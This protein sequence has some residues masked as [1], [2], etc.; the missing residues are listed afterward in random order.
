MGR[1]FTWK[2]AMK[3]TFS[4]EREKD[5]MKVN[6][7]VTITRT[8]FITIAAENAEEAMKIVNEL[9]MEEIQCGANWVDD[10]VATD[11]ELEMDT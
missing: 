5:N 2:I 7:D 8:G 4:A 6:F 11:A 3:C 10:V 1:R 9:P